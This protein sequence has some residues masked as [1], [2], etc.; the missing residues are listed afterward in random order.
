M[1]GLFLSCLL[2]VV[3]GVALADPPACCPLHVCREPCFLE[4]D[5][6]ARTLESCM[7]EL[8]YPK[9]GPSE[10]LVDDVTAAKLC[11]D[12]VVREDATGLSRCVR[13]LLFE[14][15]GLGSRRTWMTPAT[16]AKACR[17]AFSLTLAETVQ[18]CMLKQ[19]LQREGLSAERTDVPPETA[20]QGC[21]SYHPMVN[22]CCRIPDGDPKQAF[23]KE[24]HGRFQRSRD[25]RLASL[26]GEA[27]TFL[28][29]GPVR[30]L[31][32]LPV[33]QPDPNAP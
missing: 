10:P 23:L 14:R 6:V 24:C 27:I 30:P 18:S 22:S 16:A 20:A 13:G 4:P 25:P 17:G 3:P 26:K 2:S 28:C 12:V 33:Q 11:R 8:M 21:Q 5:S 1:R 9:A 29:E 31:P 7:L 32:V 19:L 15:D